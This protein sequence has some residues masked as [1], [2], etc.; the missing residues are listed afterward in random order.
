MRVLAGTAALM[1]VLLAASAA[2]TARA[3]E[4]PVRHEVRDLHYGDVLFHFFQDDYFDALVRLEASRD[5]KRLPNS[6][7]EAD[8]LAGGMY[9]SLG[10]HVEATRI[11]DR[12][13]SGT[14]PPPVAD[15]AHF[16]LARIGY[17]RGYYDEAAR[18]LARIGA[19]LPAEL[20]PGRR[21]L[22]SNVLMAQGRYADAAA[23]LQNWNDG[24]QW[25]AYARFNLGVA[26]LRA[27][28][29]AQGRQL[30]EAVGTMPAFTEEE[31]SLRDRANLALGFALLQEH[32][33][34]AAAAAL[35]RVR[36]DGPFTNRA[37]LGLGWAETD[38]QRPERA[39]VPWLE[40]RN[41]PLL[42][43]A[44]QES[45]LAVP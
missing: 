24:S 7:E 19:A 17:Q 31:R 20:E 42:D 14:A 32:S 44:V 6:A 22:A 38:A 41:R 36:L 25:A 21:L 16:Y 33:G 2:R 23:A 4:P 39:L 10:L 28:D 43:S 37:L 34:D 35:N 11:F 45:F 30:L 29:P 9:L 40:L 5:F 13:L 27:G 12:L 3:G 26:V 1:T 18:S 8:L 15:R